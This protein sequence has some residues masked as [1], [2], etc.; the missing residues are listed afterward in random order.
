MNLPPFSPG[1]T[2]TAPYTNTHPSPSPPQF[3]LQ[4][5]FLI[6]ELLSAF[7]TLLH[8][9]GIRNR[10]TPAGC[11][12]LWNLLVTHVRVVPCSQEGWVAIYATYII[13]LVSVLAGDIWP[14]SSCT[15]WPPSQS[16]SQRGDCHIAFSILNAIQLGIAAEWKT[17]RVLQTHIDEIQP[18]VILPEGEAEDWAG[19][20]KKIALHMGT[21][22]TDL[23]RRNEDQIA[24]PS[25]RPEV[26]VHYGFVFSGQACVV[27]QHL[28]A[29]SPTGFLPIPGI[30]VS[31]AV[32]II[33]GGPAPVP[34]FALVLG[35]LV[36]SSVSRT[37]RDPAIDERLG[38]VWFS[39][40][41]PA[42]LHASRFA[43]SLGS[44]A[45]PSPPPSPSMDP[46]GPAMP[47]PHRPGPFQEATPGQSTSDS[48]QAAT[49]NRGR[50]HSLLHFNFRGAFTLPLL[51]MPLSRDEVAHAAVTSSKL[52]KPPGSFNVHHRKLGNG[53]ISHLILQPISLLSGNFSTVY[54]GQYLLGNET[55]YDVLL[56]TYPRKHFPLLV[57]EVDAY[58]ALSSLSVVVPRM[59]T[60]LA[61]L[62]LDWAGLVLEN[63]GQALDSGSKSWDELC[64]T[65]D[66]K[67][68][69]YGALT[70]LH[71]AGVTHGDI[72]PR[73]VIRRRHGALC[74]VDFGQSSPDH[75]C[76][77]PMCGELSFLRQALQLGW[78]QGEQRTI[79]E[80][81]LVLQP[82][83]QAA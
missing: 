11:L 23:T 17:S 34:I 15:Y 6:P 52:S 68:Q 56:K 44:P 64:L 67:R 13:A 36:Q 69:L 16:Y 66:E 27:A 55:P 29:T 32:Q 31:T 58:K 71:S 57:R 9:S 14:N 59:Y 73:N 82:G 18:S 51:L 70:E 1:Y 35:A 42:L 12:Q 81:V 2:S 39:Q 21:T 74:F 62:S 5:D 72:C 7:S 33:P 30:A 10:R 77:G 8:S 76:P 28:L 26:G 45:G 4:D 3:C 40:T 80:P 79:R 43:S 60:L 48:R 83:V 46:P 41:L 22:Y 19:I 49:G 50:Q 25:A 20:V 47:S 63:A 78:G 38:E 53:I 75:T 24:D 61:P 37:F 54:R 65:V